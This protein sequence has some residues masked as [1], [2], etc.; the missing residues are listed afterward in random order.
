MRIP[1]CA[2]FHHSARSPVIE[3]EPPARPIRI[4]TR[5]EDRGAQWGTGSELRSS[6]VT[7]QVEVIHYNVLAD[8]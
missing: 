3:T 5:E 1:P 2:S 6:A 8:T 7:G 4:E